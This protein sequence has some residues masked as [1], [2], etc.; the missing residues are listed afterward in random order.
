[1]F[2]KTCDGVAFAHSRGV[3]H[4]DLKPDNIMVGDYGEV[5]VM[6]WGLAKIVGRKDKQAEEAITSS[7]ADQT[8]A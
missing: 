2:L 6:D 3:V 4:R 7:R 1:V 5:L 8:S